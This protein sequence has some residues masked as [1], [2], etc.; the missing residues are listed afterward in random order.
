[1][2]AYVQ[3]LY[4][5]TFKLWCVLIEKNPHW[6]SCKIQNAPIEVDEGS[7]MQFFQLY[8]I[9]RINKMFYGIFLPLPENEISSQKCIFIIFQ[10][11]LT[12]TVNDT[13]ISKIL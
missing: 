9:L 11:H 10:K 5:L 3:S 7:W 12:Q 8:V 1:M 4:G 13:F 2:N 6:K